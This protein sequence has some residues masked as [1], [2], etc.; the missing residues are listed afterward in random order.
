M[1]FPRYQESTGPY[2]LAAYDALCPGD[3]STV[4][5]NAGTRAPQR[6][7]RGGAR[8]RRLLLIER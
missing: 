2:S 4:M 3:L 1:T 7:S 8:Q 5:I 6:S